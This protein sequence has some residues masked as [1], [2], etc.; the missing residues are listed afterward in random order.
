MGVDG[1]VV[2]TVLACSALLA[3]SCSSASPSPTAEQTP[4][5]GPG[6]ALVDLG[7]PSAVAAWTTVN[8]PVMGGRSISRVTFAD[9]G[10]VFSGE[11]SLE[12]NGGFASVRSPQDAEIGRKATG[13]KALRVHAR[14]DGKTYVLSVGADAQPWSYIQRFSTEDDVDR[15]YELP[16]GDFE[17]VGK[18]FDPAP[19]APPTLDPSSIDEVSLYILDKQQGPFEIAVRALDA[20]R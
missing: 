7:D 18:R 5:A 14:G 6:V 15:I 10:L 2:A 9:G 8:D 4:N 19:E 1:R 3:P 12:N 16:V 11:V 17:P 13:A 20:V